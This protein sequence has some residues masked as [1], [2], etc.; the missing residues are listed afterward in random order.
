MGPEKLIND[1]V[2]R[3]RTAAGTNLVSAILYG[4]VAAGDY[5][6]D[7][8]DVNLLFVLRDTSFA[9]INALAPV[10]QWWSK[11]KHRPPLLMGA[12]EMRLWPTCSPSSL[13]TCGV[14]TACSGAKTS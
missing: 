9:S 4:S 12:E 10:I 5:V 1:F 2:E 6:A 3:M 8:S 13:S 7:Y 11:Q 14:T